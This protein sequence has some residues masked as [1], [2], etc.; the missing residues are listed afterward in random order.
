MNPAIAVLMLTGLTTAVPIAVAAADAG[1]PVM[2]QSGRVGWG[3]LI[4]PTTQWGRHGEQD[5]R[6][7]E[8]IA[9]QT[10]LNLDRAWYPVTADK[11]D[12]LCRY[13]FLF[14]KDLLRIAS[15]EHLRNL[16][17]YVRRGGFICIDPCV[18]GFSPGEKE[19]LARQYGQLF[20]RLFP[21]CTMRVLPDEH[22]IYHCY[23][24]V[25]V[26]ELYPPQMIRAGAIKPPRIGLRGIFLDDRM[27]AAVSITGLECGW[28]E[29]P[30]RV[31]ACLKMITNIY[32][33]AMT[34]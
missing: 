2:H 31:P 29:T 4:T 34:R 20:T 23:F 5:P 10:K 19:T 9:A 1:G 14:A 3:R 17:E 33:Y 30:D 21:A 6:L 22:E 25:T 28:P 12:Q 24:S 32:V 8:F 11:L 13:P 18:N 16:Q 26:D 27:I 7:T 15:P